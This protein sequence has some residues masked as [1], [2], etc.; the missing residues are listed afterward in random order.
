MFI[1]AVDIFNFSATVQIN[2]METVSIN[3]VIL[4]VRNV[5]MVERKR[6]R[7]KSIYFNTS[8]P[9]YQFECHQQWSYGWQLECSGC[10]A[11]F[12]LQPRNSGYSSPKFRCITSLHVHTYSRM[13]FINANTLYVGVC[14]CISIIKTSNNQVYLN[15]SIKLQWKCN[16]KLK[17]SVEFF[18]IVNFIEQQIYHQNIFFVI[19]SYITRIPIWLATNVKPHTQDKHE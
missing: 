8:H 4:Y 3:C 11:D 2:Y 6:E 19:V 7:E 10:V 5:Y 14:V 9:L 12:T 1:I 13:N 17:H 16:F 18:V 15:D